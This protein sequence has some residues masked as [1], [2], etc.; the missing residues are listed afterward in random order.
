M[1][2]KPLHM[3]WTAEL[4]GVMELYLNATLHG[5]LA[6]GISLSVSLPQQQYYY[7]YDL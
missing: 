1:K 7:Y 2:K 4:R 3:S 5:N 6:F